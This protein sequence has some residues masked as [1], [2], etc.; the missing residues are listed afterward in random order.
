MND[1]EFKGYVKAKLETHQGS[2]NEL[3]GDIKEIRK[4]VTAL[5]V[6][7]AKGGMI[8]GAIT[9]AAAFIVLWVKSQLK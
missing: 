1:A 5:K 8:G 7:S 9:T 6:S 4:G 3:K 2:L